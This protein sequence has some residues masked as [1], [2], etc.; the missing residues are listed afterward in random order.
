MTG[1][2]TS[3][4]YRQGTPVFVGRLTS[5]LGWAWKDVPY[6]GT[7]L[8]LPLPQQLPQRLL[9]QYEKQFGWNEVLHEISQLQRRIFISEFLYALKPQVLTLTRFEAVSFVANSTV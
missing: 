7:S 6:V 4:A 8:G 3:P 9:T 1:S 2:V 5:F